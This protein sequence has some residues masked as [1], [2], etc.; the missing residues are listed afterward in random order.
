MKNIK[1]DT[2]V[3]LL[4]V[5]VVLSY[6]FPQLAFSKIIS[7]N[8]VISVGIAL[9]FFFYGL[10]LS[11]SDIKRDLRNVKLHIVIQLSTFILFPFL[12]L[13][14]KPFIFSEEGEI[15]W[16]SFMFLAA[17]PS[18]VS[19]SVVMVSLA[20]GN[21]SASIF[22]ATV[23]G[24]VGVFITPI[25]MSFFIEPTAVQYDLGVIYVKLFSEILAPIVL[26]LVLQ[27]YFS[28]FHSF[29][30]KYSSFFS[31]FDKFVILLIVYNSFA[32]SFVE[33]TFQ[34][35]HIYDF[36]IITVATITLFFI[37]YEIIGWVSKKMKFST[38]DKIAAQFCGTK[39]SLLHGTVFSEILFGSGNIPMGIILL[40]IML[41]HAFQIFVI[42][43]IA[44]KKGTKTCA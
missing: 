27:H 40:P 43:I 7:L 15:I 33:K 1:L 18:T 30:K 38:E 19:S 25:W 31:G 4:I 11:F 20:K 34:S 29:T 22:N 6:F 36:I 21:V 9:I 24:L 16:L 23:S 17:I 10:K 42:S 32:V 13:L 14:A 26:G 44:T 39:K 2:F 35:V 8:R 37:V 28:Y 3:I 41:F 12:V 5:S